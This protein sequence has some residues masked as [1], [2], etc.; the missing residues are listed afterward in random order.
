MHEVFATGH[1][2]LHRADPRL[3]LVAGLI[4]AV[5]V[6]VVNDLPALW[7][8]LGGGVVLAVLARLQ[9]RPLVKRL[10]GL[11]FFFLFMWALVL[12]S[13]G[14]PLFRLWFLTGSVEGFHLAL[15][16]TLK[17]NAILLVTLALLATSPVFELFHGLQQ[18]RLPTK[19]VQLFFFIYRYIH[20]FLME[21]R[22]L[23]QAMAARGFRPG[24]NRHTYRSLGYLIGGLLNRSAER[25]E[26]IYAAMLARGFAGRFNVLVRRPVRAADVAMAGAVTAFAGWLVVVS[27]GV[28]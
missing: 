21:Y 24:T 10:L 13:P 11:N 20:E 23:R 27:L 1:S 22:R 14:T 17:G 7:W 3:K 2:F 26:R 8:G 6:A 15:V 9:V 19:L 18:M 28:S 12:F 16:I 4:L 5:V 25:A